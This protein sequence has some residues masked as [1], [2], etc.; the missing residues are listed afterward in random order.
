MSRILHRRDFLQVGLAS[1]MILAGLPASTGLRAQERSPNEKLNLAFVGVNNKGLDNIQQLAKENVAVLCD[2][3]HN[4]LDQ[5]GTTYPRAVRYRDYRMMLEKE[6]NIDAVVVST[7]DHSHAVPTALAITLGKPV[8][9]EKPLTHTV[10][11]ARHIAALAAKYKVVTQMGTQIHAS[12]NYRRVVELIRTGAIGPVSEVY[13]WCN[14]GWSNG[15]FGAPKPVPE[16]LDWDLWLGPA[17]KRD[18]CEGIH[19]GNWR[20]FWEYGSG[21]FGDMACHIMDLPYWALGLR[22]PRAITAEGP[23]VDAVGAPSWVK[24]VF[25]FAA[26][27]HHPTI[28]LHWS[29][30]NAHYDAVKNTRVDGKPVNEWGLGILFVGSKGSLVADYGRHYLLP[31]NQ[32]KEFRRPEK[33]IP[34]SIGHWNEFAKAVRTGGETTCHFGYSAL[35]TECILLGVVA[36]RSGVKVEYD[37]EKG[38]TDNETARK[39]L[40]KA[41]RKGFEIAG[42]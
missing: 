21:T 9:C 18:Y 38:T 22:Y 29:D 23:P 42:M 12:N 16:N 26:M 34:D 28:K 15:K 20:R 40:T 4:F 8:Y 36:Y 30:G 32:F 7:A 25:E 39:F 27:K 24:C 37:V 14:K 3:D 13:C 31:E 33:T 19:P 11:E 17:E 41:Y 10:A 5:V 35:L 1:G 2:V 6:K